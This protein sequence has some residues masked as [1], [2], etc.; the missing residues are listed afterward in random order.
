MYSRLFTRFTATL[1]V[2]LMVFTAVSCGGDGSSGTS[3]TT[4]A[5][6]Q[7]QTDSAETEPAYNYPTVKYD[8]YKFRVINL[9]EFYNCYVT[10]DITEQTGEAV[11]DEVYARNAKIEDMLDIEINEIKEHFAGW[12]DGVKP[13]DKL[14]AAVLAGDDAYDCGYLL[15]SFKPAVMTDGHLINLNTIPELQLDKEW[16][17]TFLNGTLEIGGKLYAATSPLQLTSLDLSWV[18]LFNKH[19]F[20]SYKIDYPYQDVRDGSWTI[21]NMNEY[22]NKLVNLNGDDDFGF[23][24]DG[25]SIY[26]VAAHSATGAYLFMLSAGNT[27]ISRKDDG[28][29]YYTG[30]SERLFNSLEKLK[31]LLNVKQG[32]A[33]YNAQD[34]LDDTGGGYY[35]LFINN[36]AAFLTT[37]LKG[38]KVMRVMDSDY[39]ILPAPKYDESQDNYITYCSENVGRM[40]IPVTN[41]DLARTGII[42]DVLSYESYANV[43]PLYYDSTLSQ[44]GLRDEDSIEMLNIIN[45]GRMTEVGKIYGTTSALVNALSDMVKNNADTAASI[46]ASNAATVESN[47]QKLVEAIDK[48][49]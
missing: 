46:M 47:L 43:L 48:L 41:S 4:A 49:P 11:D 38:A 2:L 5:D 10:I 8:G 40:S 31:T 20:D 34:K 27:F 39:G 35:S 33:L 13:I 21:D 44:K 9:D 17:D 16:W 42:L 18:L 3:D 23:K 22:L 25:N 32:H 1:L 24:F 29:L 19:L 37:E 36:R 45:V 6:E 28:S 15:L 30:E 26:G 12:N 7:V 14:S